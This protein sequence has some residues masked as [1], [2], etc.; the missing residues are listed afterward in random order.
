MKILFLS[1]LEI[2]SINE[3]NIYADLMREFR[4]NG[5]EL[6]IVS[7]C[8]R[9]KNLATKFYREEG[10]NYLRVRIGN[11]TQTNLV[12]KGISTLLLEVQ[13][14]R[15]IKKHLDAVKFDLVLFS[16]PPITFERIIRFIKRRDCAKSYLLLKDIFPQNAV[17]LEYFSKKSILYRYFRTKEK[18]LYQ[19]ADHIGCM[20]LA[21]VRYVLRHNPSLEEHRVE[22]CPNSIEPVD[23]N[24][25]QKQIIRIRNQYNIPNDKTV[26]I[27]GGNLGKPQG[28]NFLKKCIDS[29]VE[30]DQFFFVVVGSGTEF[31][32]LESFF[33]KNKPK[34]ARLLNYLSKN[35]YNELACACDVGLIFLDGRFTIPNYPSRLLSYMQASIP[36]LACTDVNSDVG[37]TIEE[38]NFGLWCEHGDLA[39]FRTLVEKMLDVDL[40]EK[41]GSNARR[42]LEDHYTSKHSYEII[43]KHFQ[44]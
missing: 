27:Y 11:I 40:R 6:F 21:N 8:Q 25:D 36:I 3:N 9:K 16:T 13:L 1:L 42:Y 34:N 4:T 12:E 7:P 30:S 44:E 18:K 33:D 38:N 37:S 14:L 15:A 19:L 41:M 22:V 29:S 35:H 24:L 10:A 20:S 31:A 43:M 2:S 28:V 26:F 39:T 5:H 23:L 32:S 17:D